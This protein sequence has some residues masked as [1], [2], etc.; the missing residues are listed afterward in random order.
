MVIDTR[1]MSTKM[2]LVTA[3]TVLLLCSNVWARDRTDIIHLKN[4]DRLTGEIKQLAVLPSITDSG[5]TRG[6]A[7]TSDYG[8]VTSIGYSF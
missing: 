3:V 5:R 4:G 7:S 6:A 1:N 8:V 2:R